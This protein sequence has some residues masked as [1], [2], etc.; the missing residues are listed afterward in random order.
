VILTNQTLKRMLS[1]SRPPPR[2]SPLRYFLPARAVTGEGG[3]SARGSRLRGSCD[4]G[5]SAVAGWPSRHDPSRARW[6]AL[7]Q[8]LILNLTSQ[9]AQGVPKPKSA[10]LDERP[11]SKGED[12]HADGRIPR[13]V[14]DAI[15]ISYRSALPAPAQTPNEFVSGRP[16]GPR[17][18]GHP[19][20]WH[21]WRELG[22][23]YVLVRSGCA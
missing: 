8:R 21:L 5:T 9:Q 1:A 22:D 2:T 20:E 16:G 6:G 18:V 14:A 7:H 10:G 3:L 17:V 12:P 15:R 23:E 4:G 13:C 11:T 19:A